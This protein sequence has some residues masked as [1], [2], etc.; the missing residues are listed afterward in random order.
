MTDSPIHP[1]KARGKA[2]TVLIVGWVTYVVSFVLP[3]QIENMWGYDAFWMY[4][5]A[6]LAFTLKVDRDR[7]SR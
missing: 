4:F 2:R 6:F 5:E 3:M 7:F 1:T